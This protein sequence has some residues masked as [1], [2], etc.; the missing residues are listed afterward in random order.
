MN[1]TAFDG[2]E[3]L[4]VVLEGLHDEMRGILARFDRPWGSAPGTV[5]LS[6]LI[7]DEAPRFVYFPELPGVDWLE[8]STLAGESFGIMTIEHGR[9]QAISWVT[10]DGQREVWTA[11]DGVLLEPELALEAAPT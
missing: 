1:I 7:Q 2:A 4:V 9:L 6:E 8:V 10:P 3:N 11:E 5:R